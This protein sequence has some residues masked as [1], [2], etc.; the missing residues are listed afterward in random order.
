[1]K[2][3]NCLPS[4]DS[5]GD[6]SGDEFFKPIGKMTLDGYSRVNG[7][8]SSRTDRSLAPAKDVRASTS[9]KNSK[10]IQKLL[11]LRFV[12]GGQEAWRNDDGAS[13][14]LDNVDD[15][16]ISGDF[17]DLEEGIES[18][19]QADVE[20]PSDTDDDLSEEGRSAR[21]ESEDDE[22]YANEEI[23]RQLRDAH[24]KKKMEAKSKFDS[25]Y[26]AKKEVVLYS[27]FTL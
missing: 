10:P 27:H 23:D 24:A 6:D 8:D 17:E 22:E 26:D 19:G 1:M 20:D 13:D 14:A 15:A 9:M 11:R 5:D 3:E 25:E 12:T 16:D 4:D 2:N 21:T 18:K 7:I